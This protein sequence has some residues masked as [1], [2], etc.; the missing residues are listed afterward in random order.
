MSSACRFFN[1]FKLNLVH[2]ATLVGHSAWYTDCQEGV[3]NLSQCISL[4]LSFLPP[5]L[6]C[7]CH[8]YISRHPSMYQSSSHQASLFL[9]LAHLGGARDGCYRELQAR[10]SFP[11]EAREA[12]ASSWAWGPSES[13]ECK[14]RE[15]N[16]EGCE[17]RPGT[18]LLCCDSI[19]GLCRGFV[20]NTHEHYIT[21]KEAATFLTKWNVLELFFKKLKR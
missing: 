5:F 15:S 8:A 17:V 21:V 18:Y 12:M 6:I 10:V 13:G 16:V 20:F 19:L 11:T 2:F 1:C 4:H 9:E 3:H 7:L 14:A